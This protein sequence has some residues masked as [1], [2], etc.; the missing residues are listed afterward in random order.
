MVSTRSY[1]PLQAIVR[2][3]GFPMPETSSTRIR[4]IE[5]SGTTFNV[6]EIAADEQMNVR[7]AAEQINR[8]I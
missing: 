1:S 5:A 3:Y 2:L 8:L 6:W 7:M 4:G